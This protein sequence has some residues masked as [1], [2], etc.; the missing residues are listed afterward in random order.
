[1]AGE[2]V[3]VAGVA[4]AYYE[5]HSNNYIIDYLLLIAIVGHIVVTAIGEGFGFFGI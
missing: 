3:L 2:V 4:E 5:F 1:M